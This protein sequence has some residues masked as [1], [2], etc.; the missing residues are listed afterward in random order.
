MAPRFPAAFR[1]VTK[2]DGNSWVY[3]DDKEYC[4]PFATRADGLTAVSLLESGEAAAALR[5]PR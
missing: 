1:V 5:V 3:R 2:M 4:G